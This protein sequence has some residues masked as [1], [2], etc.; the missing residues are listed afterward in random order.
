LTCPPRTHIMEGC[1]AKQ[2]RAPGLVLPKWY[3]LCSCAGASFSFHLLVAMSTALIQAISFRHVGEQKV[4][5]TKS[6]PS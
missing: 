3:S 4:Y 2:Q 6:L 1:R 5:R